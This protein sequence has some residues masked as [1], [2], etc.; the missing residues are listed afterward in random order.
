MKTLTSVED[1]TPLEDRLKA[2]VELLQTLD[3]DHDIRQLNLDALQKLIAQ[4]IAKNSNSPIN[5]SEAKYIGSWYYDHE[6]LQQV[7]GAGQ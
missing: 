2:A 6:H 4:S 3:P 1:T 5:W 7:S